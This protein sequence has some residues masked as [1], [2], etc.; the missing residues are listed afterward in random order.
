VVHSRHGSRLARARR[1]LKPNLEEFRVRARHLG[2]FLTTILALGA[3]AHAGAQPAKWT[4]QFGGIYG[5]YFSGS[6][7][8]NHADFTAPDDTEDDGPMLGFFT[9]Y[10]KQNTRNTVFG[11]ELVIPVFMF[12][13]TASEVIPPGGPTPEPRVD[14]EADP[15]WGGYVNLSIG[16]AI[17]QSLPYL[18]VGGGFMK[19][20]GRT[21]NVDATGA[22]APGFEQSATETHF[23]WQAGAGL[24]RRIGESTSLGIQAGAFMVDQQDYT[25]PWTEPGPDELGYE[26]LQVRVHISRSL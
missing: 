2:I 7:T 5:A 13:G 1:A 12:E 25:L 18:Y 8:S 22:P 14:Y 16:K 23:V 4:G 3:T 6:V 26:S 15:K 9:G 17:R 10:R 19:V 11:V 21:F 20:E 24:D